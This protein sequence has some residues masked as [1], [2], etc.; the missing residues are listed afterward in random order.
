VINYDDDL[1]FCC[2][3]DEIALF[4]AHLSADKLLESSGGHGLGPLEGQTEG[5]VPH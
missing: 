4:V 2:L 3:R 5:A 1:D